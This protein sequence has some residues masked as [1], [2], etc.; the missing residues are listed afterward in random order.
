MDELRFSCIGES[1]VTE[2]VVKIRNAYVK[3]PHGGF[4]IIEGDNPDGLKEILQIAKFMGTKVE[5]VKNEGNKWEVKIV[6]E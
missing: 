5:Y 3:T 1:C 4:F 6:K 2:H